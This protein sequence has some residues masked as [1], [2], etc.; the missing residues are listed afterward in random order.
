MLSRSTE[1]KSEN[2]S[3]PNFL[4]LL[5]SPRGI[6]IVS[7]NLIVAMPS[8]VKSVKLADIFDHLVI[9]L[10]LLPKRSSVSFKT[11]DIERASASAEVP[12]KVKDRDKVVS[13]TIVFMVA[14]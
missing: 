5:R 10:V 11:R 9:F 7:L 13:K 14:W 12:V 2:L 1:A 8:I 4:N 6:L 3:T